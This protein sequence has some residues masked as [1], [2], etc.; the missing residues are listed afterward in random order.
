MMESAFHFQQKLEKILPYHHV[1][2]PLHRL[3]EQL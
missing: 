1:R 3:Q 2:T